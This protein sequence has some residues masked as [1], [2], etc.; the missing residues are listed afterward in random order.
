MSIE[1]ISWPKRNKM[2]IRWSYFSQVLEERVCPIQ[3]LRNVT[4]MK[5]VEKTEEVPYQDCS[6]ATT[7][8][9]KYQIL[10]EDPVVKGYCTMLV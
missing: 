2:F 4:V 8:P 9:D 5:D 10:Q 1:K 3:E 7:E 6:L